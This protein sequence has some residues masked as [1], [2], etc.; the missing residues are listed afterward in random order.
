[1]M[2]EG[3]LKLGSWQMVLWQPRWVFGT[4]EGVCYQKITSDERPIGKA[5]TIYFKDVE[6]IDE[7]EYGEFQIRVKKRMY[8]FKCSPD[9][10]AQV[11]PLPECTWI[12]CQQAGSQCLFHSILADVLLTV[13]LAQVWVHNLRQLI[14]RNRQS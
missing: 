6:G 14:E 13:V 1:M 4:A 12:S 5:K 8:T 3:H 10:K 11:D 9:S 2:Q 7:L